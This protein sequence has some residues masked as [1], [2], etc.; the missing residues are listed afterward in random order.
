MLELF[1]ELKFVTDNLLFTYAEAGIFCLY[2][3]NKAH[4]KIPL[5]VTCISPLGAHF[6]PYMEIEADVLN[7]A[8][9]CELVACSCAK[10]GFIFT[11]ILLMALLLLVYP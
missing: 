11:Y 2:L 5:T 8:G 10:P 9:V 1:S 4:T 3:L 6:L 7:K